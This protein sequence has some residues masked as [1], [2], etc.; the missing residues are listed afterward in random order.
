MIKILCAEKVI[1]VV[2]IYRYL[3]I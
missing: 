2:R 3:Y 1:Q